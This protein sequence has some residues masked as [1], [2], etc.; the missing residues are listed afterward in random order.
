MADFNST[1]E[2]VR[3][4]N[5]ILDVVGEYVHL[6]KKGSTYFGLCPF[7]NEKT[8]SFSVTPS[9]QMYYCFGCHKG[10][11]VFTFL[12]E[13][14]NMTFRE[15]LEALA[16]RAGITLPQYNLTDED[17]ARDKKRQQ[18]LDI[19]KAAA[20]YYAYK[21]KSPQ[22]A[23][24]LEYFKSRGLN[25]DTITRFG[26]GFAAISNDELVRYLRSKG[27]EDQLMIEAG[28]ASFDEKRGLHDRFWNRVMYPIQDANNRVI[29]FGGRVMGD[30]EPK[31][32]NSK[33]TMVFDKGRNLYGLN[34]AR[35][36]REDYF[37]LCEGY[38]DVIAMHQAGFNMAV[39]SLGT[40]F[41]SGQATIVHR[42][43]RKV[44]LAYDSDGA[45][46]GAALK[47]ISILRDMEMNC[48]VI[49][50]LPHK[51]P[52]EFIKNL[53]ADEFKKRIA[54]AEDAFMFEMRIKARDYDLSDAASRT[55]FT[56]ELASSL[57]IF[58]DEVRRENYTIAICDKYQIPLDQ[59]KRLIIS[60]AAKG[61]HTGASRLPK[62]PVVSEM[63][64]QELALKNQRYLLTWLSDDPSIYPIVKKYIEP[65]DL[66]DELYRN[67]LS[68]MY[69]DIE[70]GRPNPA[71]I[72]STFTD[73]EDQS[74]VASLFNTALITDGETDKGAALH[75]I[76]YMIKK[77][78]VDSRSKNEAGT[79]DEASLMRQMNDKKALE[80]LRRVTIK[81]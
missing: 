67:V 49:N 20:I 3:S 44:Y 51:D 54:E 6:Q 9:K 62:S 69:A 13:Y 26:L 22:G 72:I 15:A 18:M 71:A 45:G 58:E 16:Q 24:G 27:Y 12:Q 60:K 48:R 46:T 76:I 4:R 28:L 34:I 47:A 1:V 68:Q 56:H 77:S 41:T 2:E 37:I 75:D 64:D 19:N 21:L 66:G 50:M 14:E 11:N 8:A 33:E 5:D 36:T 35:T 23:Q 70:N 32:L 17:R 43:V 38:M 53:G 57:L 30:G 65:D 42:F 79:I 29:G 39:A 52:D 81:L 10:G 74:R 59:L 61:E 78:A 80:E 7:H 63:S 55:D 25:D 73:E 31:Y 40:A